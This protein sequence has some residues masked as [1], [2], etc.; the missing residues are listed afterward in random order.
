MP[1]TKEQLYDLYVV[2][3]LTTREIA[4]LVGLKSASTVNYHL[5]RHK[6]PRRPTGSE[7]R[8][9]DERDRQIKI[10]F[11][12]GKTDEEIG[13]ALNLQPESVR[14]YR[15]NARLLHPK[16][17]VHSI[18]VTEVMRDIAKRREI[19]D[20]I[21]D[22]AADYNLSGPAI[23]SIMLRYRAGL[24]LPRHDHAVWLQEYSEG[25]SLAKIAIAHGVTTP[26]V[27]L[28]LRKHGIDTSLRKQPSYLP[29]CDHEVRA[30]QNRREGLCVHCFRRENP[31]VGTS[32]SN[33]RRMRLHSVHGSHSQDEWKDK[34]TAFDNLCVYCGSDGKLTRDHYIPISKGG[35]DSISNIVPACKSCNSRKSASLN[36]AIR[37]GVFVSSSGE[38]TIVRVSG[39]G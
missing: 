21:K 29:R 39:G 5:V 13:T 35:T 36:W 12:A 23:N 38:V 7:K 25:V 24:N 37:R 10:L 22:I 14:K 30:G 20:T 34:K 19:G 18:V 26:C 32:Y 11:D 6:I 16:G 28:A 2:R 31:D 4:D 8:R 27:R 9:T 17:G 3:E 15:N 1:L 33:R